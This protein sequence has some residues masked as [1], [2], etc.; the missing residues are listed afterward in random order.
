MSFTMCIF[1]DTT[2]YGVCLLFLFAVS[3]QRVAV[4]RAASW[5]V[6]F[7]VETSPAKVER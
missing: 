2:K 5:F 6:D 3:H 7:V 4:S 1:N